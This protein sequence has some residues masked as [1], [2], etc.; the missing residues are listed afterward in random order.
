MTAMTKMPKT[1]AM[2]LIAPPI[3]KGIPIPVVSILSHMTS[4]VNGLNIL[5]F[6]RKSVMAGKREGLR[7][8]LPLWDQRFPA[9]ACHADA[10]AIARAALS[11]EGKAGIPAIVNSI[12]ASA[13]RAAYGGTK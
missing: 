5:F 4:A 1:A 13:A 12:I 10:A 8:S 7:H 11:N 3:R 6:K 9:Q 2:I